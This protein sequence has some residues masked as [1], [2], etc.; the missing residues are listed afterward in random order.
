MIPRSTGTGNQGKV[1][2]VSRE[3]S[4]PGWYTAFRNAENGTTLKPYLAEEAV[5]HKNMRET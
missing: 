2:D 4:L 3:E 5:A 1:I